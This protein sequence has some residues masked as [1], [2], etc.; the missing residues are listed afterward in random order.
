ML[1][2]KRMCN[3]L[4]FGGSGQKPC[5]H[6]SVRCSIDFGAGDG[7]WLWSQEVESLNDMMVCKGTGE[8][9]AGGVDSLSWLIFPVWFL[10]LVWCKGKLVVN[11]GVQALGCGVSLCGCQ[12]QRGAAWVGVWLH[13]GVSH[14]L[15]SPSCSEV[16]LQVLVV[17]E[18][19]SVCS[20]RSLWLLT[21]EF[22]LLADPLACLCYGPCPSAHGES[23]FPSSSADINYE[24]LSL[25][26]LDLPAL[27]LLRRFECCNTA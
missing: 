15:N 14:V 13:F 5:A 3:F 17:L 26:K 23:F 24:R 20:H 22:L 16:E 19:G 8:K 18:S 1:G 21:L 10:C 27:P 7:S 2:R 11:R 12:N 9:P 4:V 6:G 25:L